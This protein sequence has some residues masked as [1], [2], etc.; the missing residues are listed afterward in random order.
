MPFPT[1]R[2]RRIQRLYHWQSFNPQWFEAQLKN[3]SVYCSNPRDFN[4]PWDCRP[5]FNAEI[6]DD[7][8]ERKKHI[9]WAEKVCRKYAP[10]G[11][12]QI[13]DMRKR[14]QDPIMLKRIVLEHTL[15]MQKGV[16]E[17]FRVYCLSPLAM[18]IRM[19][20][21]YGDE[22]RGICLEFDV[23]NDPIGGALEVQYY[24]QFPLTRQY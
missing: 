21:H 20:A 19:W 16:L 9:D 1:A 14:L 8:V 2:E 17:R 23:E 4:D 12:A 24:N 3:N 13:G 6:L 10:I 15:E 5:F 11:E 22:H 18:N 7:P